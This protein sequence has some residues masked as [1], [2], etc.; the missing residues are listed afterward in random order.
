M[1]CILPILIV[2][3]VFGVLGYAIYEKCKSGR[4]GPDL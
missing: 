1:E 3:A 2:V 4:Q